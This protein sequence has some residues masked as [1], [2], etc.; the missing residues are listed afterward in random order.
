MANGKLYR[1]IKLTQPECRFM[2]KNMQT[3]GISG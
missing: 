1:G 2:L 3:I